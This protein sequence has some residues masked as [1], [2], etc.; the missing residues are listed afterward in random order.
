M[1]M[2]DPIPALTEQI[3]ALRATMPE[4]ITARAKCAAFHYLPSHSACQDDPSSSDGDRF[5]TALLRDMVAME[6]CGR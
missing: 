5:E 6:R 3:I 1:A 4:G 2:L